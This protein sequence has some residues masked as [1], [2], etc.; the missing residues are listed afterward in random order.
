M[1]PTT[2]KRIATRLGDWF[3][4]GYDRLIENESGLVVSWFDIVKTLVFLA[5]A[6]VCISPIMDASYIFANSASNG[7]YTADDLEFVGDVYDLWRFIPLVGF[8]LVIFYAI[9]YS[10]WKRE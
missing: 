10:N 6:F 1:I 4:A 2:S 8:G 3:K 9:N 5:F 7:T